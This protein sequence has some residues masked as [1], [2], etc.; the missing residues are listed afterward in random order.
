MTLYA[1]DRYPI[2]PPKIKFVSKIGA[3]FVDTKGNVR[4]KSAPPP[5]ASLRR[6]RCRLHAR[7]HAA[8][9]LARSR[10]QILVARVPYLASWSSG[11][12]MMGALMEIKTLIARASRAQPVEGATY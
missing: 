12:T 9:S 7:P 2:S 10:L 3:D 11:K 1:D 8:S 6:P 4:W 5:A